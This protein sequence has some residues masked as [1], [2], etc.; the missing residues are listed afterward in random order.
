MWKRLIYVVTG[1]FC[2]ILGAWQL[3]QLSSK[4]LLT[5]DAALAILLIF[6]GFIAIVTG[7]KTEK[8]FEVK[9]ERKPRISVA[10]A[11]MKAEVEAALKNV[12][13][14]RYA[15]G[16]IGDSKVAVSLEKELRER[17]HSAWSVYVCTSNGKCTCKMFMFRRSADKYFNFLM[18]TYGLKEVE[19][20]SKT[21]KRK[22]EYGNITNV[23]K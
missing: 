4:S 9:R 7:L 6:L 13:L 20:T 18:K 8:P 21:N 17:P 11:M 23:I 5:S 10:E 2:I 12:K 22:A 19:I 3:S 15:T 1:I 14:E 16:M